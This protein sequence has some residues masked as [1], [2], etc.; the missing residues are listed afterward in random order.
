MNDPCDN[1]ICPDLLLAL[2]SS[3][4]FNGLSP[5]LIAMFRSPEAPVDPLQG[6]LK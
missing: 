3:R 4:A 6:S 1:D 5:M 2:S